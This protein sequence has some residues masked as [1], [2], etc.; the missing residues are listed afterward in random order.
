MEAKTLKALV[1]GGTGEVGRELVKQL[2]AHPAFSKVTVVGRRPFED[3][4]SD[5]LVSKQ[6]D[7]DKLQE[8]EDAFNDTQV[9][10]CCLG[11]TRANAGKEGFIKV[12]RDY[13]L[14]AAELLKKAGC[15]HFHLVTAQGSN[16]DSMFLYPKIKGET[17]ECTAEMK[18]DRLSIYR[19]GLLMCER[20][21]RRIFE[22][23]LQTFAKGFDWRNRFSVPVETVAKAMITNTLCSPDDAANQT[24]PIKEIITHDDILRLGID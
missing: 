4:Q 17:E 8:Y 5:K 9:A 21:E 2:V 11:T 12:D 14:G 20:R 1:L 18:F 23:I 15:S 19:P 24:P 7:F 13:V 22:G 10:Y 3:V 6:V 16:K